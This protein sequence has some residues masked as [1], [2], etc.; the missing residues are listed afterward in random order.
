[1]QIRELRNIIETN[2]AEN[3]TEYRQLLEENQRLRALIEKDMKEKIT[4]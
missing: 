2:E 4:R 1:M 3:N